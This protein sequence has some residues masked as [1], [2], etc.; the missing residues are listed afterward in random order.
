MAVFAGRLAEVAVSTD[1]VTFV[2]VERVVSP[3]LI[4][5][6]ET[7]NSS[8]NDSAGHEELVATWQELVLTFDMV[9]DEAAIGQEMVW[10][11]YM[12][13]T[14]LYVR[15]RPR[16]DLAL[17]VAID[18]TFQC[19]VTELG[20][21]SES[22]D[23]SRYAA[24]LERTGTSTRER[25]VDPFDP[26]SI[27]PTAYY[28]FL[29]DAGG[30][31]PD[32]SGNGN[33]LNVSGHTLLPTGGPHADIAAIDLTVNDVASTTNQV[34]TALTS[35]AVSVWFRHQ[36]INNNTTRQ[37]IVTARSAGVNTSPFMILAE[38]D[39]QFLGGNFIPGNITS[40]TLTTWHHAFI[41]FWNGNGQSKTWLDGVVQFVSAPGSPSA[42]QNFRLALGAEGGSLIS[43]TGQIA[44]VAVFANI[45][46]ADQAALM[47]E[48]RSRGLAGTRL[49]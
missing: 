49:M 47:A 19:L 35:F 37:R 27:L 48:C 23:A 31:V 46:S 4:G 17:G 9:S 22:R 20:Q 45:G 34:I 36:S 14:A 16:G 18:T 30:T 8:S 6:N 28:R 39:L 38:R 43:F 5:A 21:R 3:R 13:R 44:E 15:F 11:A 33:L 42:T 2:D 10:T 12:Q 1:G 24:K 32:S 25:Y 7:A 29:S 41:H 26:V 40:V